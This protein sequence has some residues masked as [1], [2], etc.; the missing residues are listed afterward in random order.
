MGGQYLA[1]MIHSCL[2]H[3]YEVSVSVETISQLALRLFLNKCGVSTG[4]SG[5]NGEPL[6]SLS[7]PFLGAFAF[8]VPGREGGDN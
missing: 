1:A 5:T 7:P 3:I 2:R 4:E 8:W 6:P